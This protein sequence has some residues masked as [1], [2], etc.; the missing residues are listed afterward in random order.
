MRHYPHY[1][2]G[3]ARKLRCRATE[4]ESLLWERLR[5]RR[6]AGLKFRRQ[7]HIGRYVADFYCRELDL[8]I[9]LEGCV[10]DAPDQREYDTARFGYLEATGLRICRIQNDQVTK[11]IEATLRVILRYNHPHPLGPAN[12]GKE[13]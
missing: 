9:E 2:I 13:R 8:I 1:I 4:A 5:D 7:H 3:V 6:L 11:D 10:H 12:D